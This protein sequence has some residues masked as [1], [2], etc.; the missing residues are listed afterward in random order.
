MKT[1]SLLFAAVAASDQ[2]VAEVFLPKEET[3][4]LANIPVNKVAPCQ[5]VTNTAFFDLSGVMDGDKT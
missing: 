5:Y 2:P 1:L 4:Q 3:Q